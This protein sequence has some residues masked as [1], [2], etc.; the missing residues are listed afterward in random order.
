M[1]TDQS[2]GLVAPPNAEGTSQFF[3]VQFAPGGG[4]DQK[5]GSTETTG[6]SGTSGGTK[7]ND[8]VGVRT[9]LG[10]ERL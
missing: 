1:D 8:Q 4:N 6:T 2:G 10:S 3:Y 5:S 7:Q 9:R